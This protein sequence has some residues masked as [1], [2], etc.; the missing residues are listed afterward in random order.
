VRKP[1]AEAIR[2]IKRAAPVSENARQTGARKGLGESDRLTVHR[3][4]RA[5]S[6][7]RSAP[8]ESTVSMAVIGLGAAGDAQEL[9]A[10]HN[11]M[12]QPASG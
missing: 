5:T 3:E 8:G 6:G 11:D 7:D 4:C 10:L 12:R 1:L 2:E 9:P